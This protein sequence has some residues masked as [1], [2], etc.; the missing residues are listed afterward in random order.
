MLFALDTAAATWSSAQTMQCYKDASDTEAVTV[1]PSW[2]WLSIKSKT[3]Q[4]Q[5]KG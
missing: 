2:I 4:A 5:Y 3:H 1:E